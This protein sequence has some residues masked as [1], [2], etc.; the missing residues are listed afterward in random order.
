MTVGFDKE[1]K[2][3]IARVFEGLSPAIANKVDL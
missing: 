2:L 3:K 1:S